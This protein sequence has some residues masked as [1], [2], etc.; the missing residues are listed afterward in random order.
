M[1]SKIIEQIRYKL[2]IEVE[3]FICMLKHVWRGSL[4]NALSDIKMCLISEKWLFIRS[5][6]IPCYCA[7]G[8]Q[9]CYCD[10]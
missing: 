7:I 4:K 1:L 6:G 2:L 8:L 5:S 3:Q 9:R 10:G